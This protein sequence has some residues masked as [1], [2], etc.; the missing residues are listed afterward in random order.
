MMKMLYSLQQGGGV[1]M[2]FI[3]TVGLRC[4]YYPQIQKETESQTDDS[5]AQ[6]HSP[7]CLSAF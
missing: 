5:L 7:T 1:N 6:D 2:S 3:E 4:G